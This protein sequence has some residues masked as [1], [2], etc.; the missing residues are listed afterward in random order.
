MEQEKALD[1]EILKEM[2]KSNEYSSLKLN[3]FEN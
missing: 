3:D 2:E 1:K